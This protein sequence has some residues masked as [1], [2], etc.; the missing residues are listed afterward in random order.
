ML[1]AS[2][3]ASLRTAQVCRELL[4]AT[5]NTNP[6]APR[7]IRSTS[8]TTTRR[9]YQQVVL[10]SATAATRT[11][12]L[13]SRK[14]A[15]T[16]VVSTC[17]STFRLDAG[18]QV[19][20]FSSTASST[21]STNSSIPSSIDVQ[22]Y[23]YAICPFCNRVKA[24]LDYAG[25][26]YQT[27]EVNPLTKAEIK[28]WKDQ[29]KQV[30][31]ATIDGA[32]VFESDYIIER[33]LEQPAIQKALEDRWQDNGQTTM[34]LDRLSKRTHGEAVETLCLQRVGRSV[35]SQHVSLVERQLPGL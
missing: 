6:S 16:A 25:V 19:N 22:L 32:P 33:L 9:Y 2:R 3:S 17:P 13:S 21:P 4:V 26:P 14:S 28:P 20:Q 27:T 31:I 5:T 23:Q 10:P 29:H 18:K 35:V 11:L 24:L 30:P 1:G 7:L 15:T 34:T 8:R 12:P